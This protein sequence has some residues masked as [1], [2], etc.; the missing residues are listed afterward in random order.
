M[1]IIGLIVV[2][3]VAVCI[4]VVAR[5]LIELVFRQVG[6][7]VPRAVA[8]ALAILIALIWVLWA[9]RPATTGV[10]F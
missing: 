6:I 2:A 10:W 8:G 9:V 4:F 3:L 7:D 1:L 5:Y